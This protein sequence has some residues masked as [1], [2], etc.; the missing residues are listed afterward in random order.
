[1][2]VC[3][4]AIQKRKKKKKIHSRFFTSYTIII[5]LLFLFFNFISPL[6]FL[7]IFYLLMPGAPPIRLFIV[8]LSL[9][10]ASFGPSHR[11]V[12]GCQT[13]RSSAMFST[14]L[15]RDRLPQLVVVPF[16]VVSRASS[17]SSFTMSPHRCCLENAVLRY[18]GEN[19]NMR[20]K[21]E[22]ENERERM[23]KKRKINK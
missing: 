16:G 2:E 11:I 8:L 5:I 18:A 10:D 15:K 23:K 9:Q 13:S 20:R 19:K 4:W 1:M 17:A 3:K 14:R 6:L 7:F 21:N 22:R 12:Y